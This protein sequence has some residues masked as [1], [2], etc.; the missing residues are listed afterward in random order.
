MIEQEE[1]GL[2]FNKLGGMLKRRIWWIVIPAILGPLAAIY[3]SYKITPR[4]ESQAF[5]LVEEPKVPDKFVVSVITNQ[6]DVRLMTLKE[7]ILSRSRLE[8]IVTSLSLYS[9]KPKLT[10]EEK[11]DLLRNAIEVRV[12]KSDAGNRVPSGFYI[13]AEASS[14]HT[15]QDVCS[16]I[17]SMFMDENLKVRQQQAAGTTAF[18]SDQLEESK[19]KL[20]A[21]DARLA[22]FKRRYFGQLPS[23][24]QRN[25][26]MLNSTRTRLEAVTQELST[27]QQQ[28]IV[29]ESL[30]TQQL[31]ARV[32][33]TAN[34]QAPADLQTQLAQLQDQLVALSARYTD[35]HPDV[36]KLKSQIASVKQKLANAPTNPAAQKDDASLDTPEIR[37]T[38]TAIRLAEENI[39]AKRAEQARLAQEVSALQGRLQLSPAVEEEYKAL[40]RDY[41]TALQFYNDLLSKKTQSEMATNL[42]KRQEGEQ[43]RLM[44]APD[45]PLKPTFPNRM[46]FGMAG[47][48]AGLAFGVGLGWLREKSQNFLRTEQ[49]VVYQL[50]LPVLIAL[51]DVSQ[52]SARSTYG[53]SIALKSRRNKVEAQGQA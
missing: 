45:L 36:I 14:A 16:Q 48:G 49:D 2:D 7:Q 8:P 29:Q 4:Y 41:E 33:T 10:M 46:K 31:K 3:V 53:R 9:D 22:E 34:G 20:D 6:L 26:E 35:E 52:K 37:Q 24:E 11:V 28:K 30:L 23:D 42:E 32:A 39:K 5:V 47:L 44:D 21:Q 38:R 19:R 25:L 43:F 27:A 18:L 40:T 12:I 15:A 17:L 51:P 1:Q 50:D 13:I